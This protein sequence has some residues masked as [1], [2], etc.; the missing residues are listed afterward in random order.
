MGV[1]S[2]LVSVIQHE[3]SAI[4]QKGS[5]LEVVRTSCQLVQLVDKKL[6]I[7]GPS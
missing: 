5:Q 4:S 3:I 6:L 2:S 1:F 7:A